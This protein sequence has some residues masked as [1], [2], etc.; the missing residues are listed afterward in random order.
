MEPAIKPA[1]INSSTGV[2]GV[3]ATSGTFGG[4]LYKST[5]EKYAFG[6]EVIERVGEGL[7]ELVE[8]GEL[9][10][11]R[12]STLLRRYI[13]PMLERGADHIVLGCTLYPFLIEEIV[14][15]VGTN[16]RVVNPAPAV[17]KHLY[18]LLVERCANIDL[19]LQGD[20]RAFA[21]G[22]KFYSTASVSRLEQL[23]LS[24][25]PNIPHERFKEINI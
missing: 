7:V 24:I 13:E 6:V 4:Q 3:L 25:F 11:K 10:G 20:R 22:T 12:V 2:V 9:N 1:A 18:E 5:L 14:R 19:P 21:K 16:I 15:I 8:S 17:A 23:A